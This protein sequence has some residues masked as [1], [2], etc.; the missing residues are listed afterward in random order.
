MSFI[1]IIAGSIRHFKPIYFAA[2]P[3]R[4]FMLPDILGNHPIEPK[5]GEWG[6][7]KCCGGIRK[8][9]KRFLVRYK[10]KTLHIEYI[11]ESESTAFANAKK[12]LEKFNKRHKLHKN[13]IREVEDSTGSYLQVQVGDR[14]FT[15]DIGDIGVATDFTW[16]YNSILRCMVTHIFGQKVTLHSVITEVEEKHKVKHLDGD[17]LNNRRANLKVF[18]V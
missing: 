1:K 9:N 2:A 15:I 11:T 5:Y 8:V 16:N 7:G 14:F 17:R 3:I 12:F 18:K 10:G 4:D 6:L 13:L